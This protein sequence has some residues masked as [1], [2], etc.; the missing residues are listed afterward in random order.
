MNQVETRES[1]SRKEREKRAR[2]QEILKA[3]RALFVTKGFRE[4]T[5]EEVARCAEFGKGTLYHY[6]A[7]KEDL[8]I[9]II[10]QVIDETLVLARESMA[11]PGDLRDK[12]RLYARTIIQYIKDNGEL[13]H[14]VYQELHRSDAPEN[15]AK[16][17][18]CVER[19]RGSWEILAEPFMKAVQDGTVRDLDPEQLALLFDSLLRGY[20]FHRF[21]VERPSVEEDFSA[22]AELITAV[23]FDGIAERKGKG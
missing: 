3:A 12:L 8:F 9:G 17:R 11:A 10:E 1:P 4:T 19:S 18:E 21:T 23:F 16:L 5:L 7:N 6:F 13:L 15:T 14:V 2:Q 20:C 22:A